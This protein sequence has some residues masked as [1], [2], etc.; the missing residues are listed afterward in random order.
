MDTVYA[1]GLFRKS[2]FAVM[3]CLFV[4]LLSSCQSKEKGSS[5]DNSK[6]LELHCRLTVDLSDIVV[7]DQFIVSFQIP[8]YH[9]KYESVPNLSFIVLQIGSWDDTHYSLV[10]WDKSK[11]RDVSSRTVFDG[12]PQSL[13]INSAKHWATKKSF[14]FSSRDFTVQAKYIGV[15]MVSC[16]ATGIVNHKAIANHKEEIVPQE[17][18]IESPPTIICV[19]PVIPENC[20]PDFDP[21]TR[22]K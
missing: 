22:L 14:S 13:T 9:R 11:W 2:L 8:K 19:R 12:L 4:G 21:N 7:N 20:V 5:T 10:M 3:P 6:S 16:R 1:K 17:V 18:C 15:F